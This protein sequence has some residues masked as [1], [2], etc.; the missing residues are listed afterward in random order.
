MSR[1]IADRFSQYIAD[2][3]RGVARTVG[4]CLGIGEWC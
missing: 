1:D 4:L 2:T 3:N